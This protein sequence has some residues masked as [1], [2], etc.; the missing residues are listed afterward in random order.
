MMQADVDIAVVG[1]G[2]VG[3]AAALALRQGGFSVAVIERAGP[4]PAFDPADYDL[5]VF[6]VTPASAALLAQV[7]AWPAIA[8]ARISPYSSMQVWEGAPERALVID[9]GDV[10]IAELGWIIEYRLLVAALAEAAQPL[11]PQWHREI[12]AVEWPE[13][14]GEATRLRFADGGQL[15]ARLVVAAD[16]GDSPLR[17]HAGIDISGWRYGQRALVCHV[18]TERP[19]RRTAW[20]RFL[21]EGPL[22]FLP[23][24]DGRSSIVWSAA[25]AEADAL[26]A[27]DDGAFCSRLETEL[28]G[29]LGSVYEPTR[30]IA[31]PLRLQHANDYVRPGLVLI[32]DAAHTVHPLAG[33][34]VNLG[35]GD[36]AF[37]A[38]TLAEARK[39]RRDWTS[40]RTLARY[41]RTRKAEN[42]EMLAVTDTLNR[43]FRQRTPG[44]RAAL[45]WGMHTVGRA[46]VLK[47]LL[48]RGAASVS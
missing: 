41:A 29:A 39:A 30:R 9:G 10:G 17:R 11:Q 48:L 22:A 21:P 45:G 7:G 26:L 25:E 31:F 42:L 12:T 13:L 27:L 14:E 37:L 8:A 19:H 18:H 28:Q 38:A 3:L 24:A 4:P 44:V 1:G 20:Q 43:A 33:Q 6:A 15:S 32:G 47:E 40:L 16:G 5:R 36:A 35:F 2:P 46:G 34:G 23:L